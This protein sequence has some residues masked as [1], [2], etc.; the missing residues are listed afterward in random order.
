MPQY[1]QPSPLSVGAQAPAAG[2]AEEPKAAVRVPSPVQRA[3]EKSPVMHAAFLHPGQDPIGG[4]RL[5][6]DIT[7]RIE[8][9]ANRHEV[10]HTLDL[11]T[12]AREEEQARTAARHSLGK[13][14]DGVLHGGF[15]GIPV[16]GDLKAEAAQEGGQV[17][18]IVDRIAQGTVGIGGIADE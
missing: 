2:D 10:V 5:V 8:V 3:M 14:V 7:R 12:M 16:E 6:F 13:A 18:G 4:D 11:H 15:V 9:R 17:R 1:P